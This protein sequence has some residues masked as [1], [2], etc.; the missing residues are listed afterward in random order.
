MNG[1][2]D[3]IEA[4]RAAEEALA[5]VRPSAALDERVEA[6]WSRPRVR[7]AVFAAVALV[8]AVIFA[9][10]L[11]S[12]EA[13]RVVRDE[14]ATFEPPA[15][16]P[17][18]SRAE[19]AL[20]AGCRVTI[21]TPALSFETRTAAK[22]I[23]LVDGVRVVEGTI[24]FAVEK[25]KDGSTVVV[26]VPNGRIEV[27]GTRFVVRVQGEDGDVKLEEGSIRFV[28]A[29]GARVALA[30]GGAHAWSSKPIAIADHTVEAPTPVREPAPSKKIVEPVRE[31]SPKVEAVEQ[32]AALPPARWS[33]ERT[34]LEVERVNE[35]RAEGRYQEEARLIAR[36]L[37]APLAARA[38]EVL[39]FELGELL[40][41]KL[42]RRGEAC[43]HWRTH[44]DR[45]GEGRYGVELAQ[46]I[47]RCERGEETSPR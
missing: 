28:G 25:V 7:I 23:R 27:I 12:R 30:P 15:C 26:R 14:V 16:A 2:R 46:A 17:E 6:S 10:I 20:A 24:A 44:R 39:S 3:F 43:A 11:S 47:A 37:E 35:L 36:L 19:L 32:E 21:E 8:A 31:T 33:A 5:R 45:F 34:A 4:W 1:R 9:A 42:D 22:L 18:L 40:E 41:R 38:A 29:N 13:P